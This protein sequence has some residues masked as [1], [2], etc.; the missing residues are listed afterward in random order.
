MDTKKKERCYFVID[1]K[2]FFASVECS[3]RGLDPMTTDLVVADAERSETTICLAVTPSMKAKGVKNRCRLYE[4]PKDMEYKIA[5]PQM[6]MYIKFASEIYAIYLKY[7]D[8]SDIHCYSID[9]CFLD[10][11]DY[12]KIYNMR[13]KDFAKKLMQEIWEKLKIPSTTGIGTNLFLAKIALD[14][15]AKH[16]PDRIGWLTEEKFLKELWHHKPLSDF[17]QISTGTINRLAKYGITDM[18]G[19]AHC[20]EDI[21]YNEFGVNAELLIDHS[22]GRE[23][24]L[25]SDIKNYK[26][27]GSKS[28]SNSQILPCAYKYEDAKT[29]VKEM[30]QDGCYRLAREGVVTSHIHLFLG[31]QDDRENPTKGGVRLNVSTNLFSI[32]G[33]NA[34]ELFEKIVDKNRMIRQ[35]AYTFSELQ[36]EGMEQY[37]LFTDYNAINKEK[38]LVKSILNIQDRYGKNSLLKGLDLNEKATQRER[39]NMI[40]GHRANGKN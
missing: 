9:E 28:F 26:P 5:P 25:M 33:K 10:V 14:I 38:K 13:A 31:Y 37:D 29:I 16:S 18:Y 40:G 3:L 6:D 35:I 12:L 19:I 4:I 30:I 2:S 34:D 15:T 27:K 17:W 7:I 1:M 22:W 23:T 36:P 39:N 24:C 8:K 21:L 11:T 32:I 20:S